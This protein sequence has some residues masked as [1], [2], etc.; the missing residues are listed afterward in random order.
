MAGGVGRP[1]GTAS[2]VPC[3]FVL[4]R[5]AAACP[6]RGAA[7]QSSAA[8]G[9]G[10]AELSRGARETILTVSLD[11]RQ[12]VSCDA[13]ARLSCEGGDRAEL[14]CSACRT[15]LIV[16]LDTRKTVLRCPR[17]TVLW[18]R[19]Q[20]WT[21]AVITRLADGGDRR[22]HVYDGYCS[23]G[24]HVEEYDISIRGILVFE[25]E[26]G[27]GLGSD[28]FGLIEFWGCTGANLIS[29]TLLLP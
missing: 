11:S 13:C 12:T 29:K 19:L 6:A 21:V 1:R 17:R 2:T 25:Y 3:R 14:S 10:H 22:R 20:G 15:V 7:E 9:D 16:P 8:R 18:W 24:T 27:Y 5:L 23:Y 26:F 4:A 28:R